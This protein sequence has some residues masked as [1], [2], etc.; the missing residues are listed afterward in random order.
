MHF[1]V[2]WGNEPKWTCRAWWAAWCSRRS[3]SPRHHRSEGSPTW[4]RRGAS[5]GFLPGRST[6]CN[7]SRHRRL[8][9]YRRTYVEQWLSLLILGQVC[10][11]TLAHSRP[12]F[13]FIWSNF[14]ATKKQPTKYGFQLDSNLDRQIRRQAH[15]P[16]EHLVSLGKVSSYCIKLEMLFSNYMKLGLT[17]LVSFSMLKT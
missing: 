9:K 17:K 3:F 12:L 8:A 16:L 11:L 2:K 14:H 15:W 6:S 5:Y 13:S 4:V 7:A 1:S 10:F